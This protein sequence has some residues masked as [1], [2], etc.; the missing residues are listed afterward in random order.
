MRMRAM[1]LMSGTSMDGIDVAIVEI[2]SVRSTDEIGMRLVAFQT[3]PY[4]ADVRD[5]LAAILTAGNPA[6]PPL[7]TVRDVCALNFAVGEAFAAA[8]VALAGSTISAIDVIGSHGQTI[9]HLPDDDG[10]PNYRKSTFQIGE[11]ALIAARTGVTCVADFRVADI[12]AGGQGAPLV[13]Y[14]DYLML[15]DVVENRVALNIGGIANLTILPAARGPADVMAF[16]VGPGNLLIDAAVAHYSQGRQRFDDRGAIA[17]ATAISV[18]LY[19]WLAGH[20]YYSRAL[21]KT[22]GRETFGSAYFATVLEKAREVGATGDVTIATLTAC[23]AN[24]IADAVPSN[25]RRVICSGGGAHNQ[26][27]IALLRAAL[28]SKHVAPPELTMSDAFGLPIDAKEAMAFALLATATVRGLPGN[29]PSATGAGRP[30]VLGKIVPG[31]NF[32]A[33]MHRVTLDGI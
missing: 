1:G 4:P 21:P 9:Y 15:R 6:R 17:A 14:L 8:A 3:V 31:D 10:S 24:A 27:T 25:V 16:D 7:A 2:E 32:R 29:L 12:A 20:P 11:P 30:A 13:S 23:A 28:G 5:A 18:P 33:L 22:T 26:T 19:E